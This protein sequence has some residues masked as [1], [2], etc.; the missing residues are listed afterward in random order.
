[1][2]G[3]LLFAKSHN[4]DLNYICQFNQWLKRFMIFKIIERDRKALL[5]K[6][7]EAVDN[8]GIRCHILQ[9]FDNNLTVAKGRW[10]KQQVAREVNEGAVFANNV[11]DTNF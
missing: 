6:T 3:N 9:H 1:M 10:I 5:F 4:I 7:L 8:V 11:V 2:F